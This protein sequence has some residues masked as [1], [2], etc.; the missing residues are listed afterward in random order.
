MLLSIF[1]FDIWRRIVY[2]DMLGSGRLLLFGMLTY[3]VINTCRTWIL[4]NNLNIMCSILRVETE[5]NYLGS[6]CP[7]YNKF[8]GFLMHYLNFPNIFD[9]SLQNSISF[10]GL[11]H[12]S[13]AKILFSVWMESVDGISFIDKKGNFACTSIKNLKVDFTLYSIIIDNSIFFHLTQI[14]LINFV[15]WGWLRWRI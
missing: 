12:F 15:R 5:E 1:F 7:F 3:H 14:M 11:S 13:F 10:G 9:C 2:I 4:N 6:V 8:Q